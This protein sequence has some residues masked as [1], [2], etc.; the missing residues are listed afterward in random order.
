MIHEHDGD[1]GIRVAWQPSFQVSDYLQ[2]GC[3]S[4]LWD[5]QIEG[6]DIWSP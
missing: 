4:E 5:H 1:M 3:L 2:R 6:L